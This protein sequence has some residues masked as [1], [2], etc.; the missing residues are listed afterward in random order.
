[1]RSLNSRWHKRHNSMRVSATNNQSAPCKVRC[2]SPSPFPPRFLNRLKRRGMNLKN[3]KP[4]MSKHI[5]N[6]P[7][8][9]CLRGYAGAAG[10]LLFVLAAAL[11][12]SCSKKDKDDHPAEKSP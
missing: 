2:N 11:L 12:L 9:S 5:F 10:T 4:T 6:Q 7:L 1:M 8:G 3:P